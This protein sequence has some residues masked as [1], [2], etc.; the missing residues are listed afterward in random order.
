MHRMI[1][2]LS[3]VY[4][5]TVRIVQVRVGH[6]L[7]ILIFLEYFC[8]YL[9]GR[10]LVSADNLAYVPL[11]NIFLN[12][13]SSAEQSLFDGRNWSTD[14]GS[15]YAA[16]NSDS[17][18]SVSLASKGTAIPA[19]PYTTARL[20]Y[21]K[22]SYN[23]DVTPGPKFIRLYFYSDS[24]L[25]LDASEAFLTV[26]AGR[27]TLLR[28]F[29]SYLTSKYLNENY[30]FKEF[31]VHVENQ[32][33]ELTFTPSSNSPNAY[34]FVNGIEVVSI[35]LH[36]YTRGDDVPIPFVGFLPNML[37]V[38][39]NSA[40]EMVYRAN[41]G[42]QTI[43][44]DQ[45]T[46]MFRTWNA[47]ES[48]IFGAAYGQID[49]DN[50]LSIQYPKT[51]PAYTAPGDV[52]RTARS[53][54]QYNEINRNYNLSW[55]FPVDTGFKYLIRLHFCEIVPGMTLENQRV[56]FIFI[57]NQTAERQADVM[58]WS[59]GHGVPVYRD[60]VVMIPQQ[61]VSKQDL[62]LELHPN[63]RVKPEYYDAILNGVE[64]F[65]ISDYFGNLAGLNP[66]LDEANA[67]PSP[68]TSKKSKKK[69]LQKQIKY[70]LVG[71]FLLISIFVLVAFVLI[72]KR[73][74][75]MKMKKTDKDSSHC[76]IFPI[77]DIRK[78]TK[79]FDK[80]R[81][82]GKW[83]F[84]EVYKGY[85]PGIDTAV[86]IK[87]GMK[88]TS[89]GSLNEEIKELY[90]IRHNNVISLLG[91]CKE[92][93]EIILVYEYTDNGP[94]SD[95]LFSIDPRKKPLTW[96]QRLE[97]C[98]GVARG[99]HH[100]HT[101]EKR[102]I[103]HCDISTSNILLDKSWRAKI[104]NFESITTSYD[105]NGSDVNGS[106]SSLNSD[107]CS[108]NDMESFGLVMLEVLTGRPAPINPK[109]EDDENGDSYD[110]NKSLIP[111]VSYCLD[112]GDAVDIHLR[113]KVP[114]E[115]LLNFKK[116]TKQCLAKIK[117]KPPT[118]TEV[119]N[120]LEQLVV[121]GD[122][123]SNASPKGLYYPQSNSD[124]MFGVEFSENMMSTGR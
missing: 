49:F 118:L 14:V 69:G 1:A 29:S 101:G 86:A 17:N 110:D 12:C 55:F 23:F 13:G 24:Y 64:I 53:M 62:W 112:N 16:S 108:K 7:N 80:S 76:R 59:K 96:N 9:H 46:G 50:T 31:I 42:G 37:T 44:P 73:K 82:I 109:A 11:E 25:G 75:K 67:L 105:S 38:D 97:I 60:Y 2:T 5:V 57:N 70:S 65:K 85:I 78:A 102:P 19:V 89:E 47:D 93:L 26:T 84:G 116:I 20:F 35:P 4:Q 66:P 113:G 6:V 40:L 39:N 15:Q 30:F 10:T 72:I 52:Y 28:N 41:V 79:N 74:G 45:D 98:I 32:S 33:L 27:Y 99:L 120:N 48:F 83:D 117:V 94:L 51:V 92:D 100:L 115:S 21:S 54:G 122:S 36:L 103:L 124:L 111:S 123:D 63:I 58:V 18:S 8:F 121:R 104:S 3:E 56:F 87:R 34:G 106:F 68:S 22:F 77:N 95:H 88:A 81:V 91:Y 61:A 114:S 71:A 107:C 119:L 43:P 90:Q